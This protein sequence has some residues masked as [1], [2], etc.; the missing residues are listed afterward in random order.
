MRNIGAAKTSS[1][2]VYDVVNSV[3]LRSLHTSSNAP[4]MHHSPVDR[5][6]RKDANFYQKKPVLTNE[7]FLIREQEYEINPPLRKGHA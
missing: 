6:W 2:Y 3:S 4:N 7:C 1:I 5:V